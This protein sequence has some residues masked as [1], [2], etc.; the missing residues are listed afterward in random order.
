VTSTAGLYKCTKSDST[1]VVRAWPTPAGDDDCDGFTNI[2]KNFVGTDP[3]VACGPNAWPPDF[4]NGR[5]VDMSDVVK[6]SP[7]FNTTGPGAPY[8]RRFDLNGDNKIDLSDV[9]ILSPFFNKPCAP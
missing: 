6:C 5:K 4:N 3:L 2:I 8:N 7:V 1:V 9:L